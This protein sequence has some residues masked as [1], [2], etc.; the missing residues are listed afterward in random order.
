[1]KAQEITK[2]NIQELIQM[3]NS[4][5][6]PYDWRIPNIMENDT[7]SL[8]LIGEK[9]GGGW[10]AYAICNGHFDTNDLYLIVLEDEGEI[11]SFSTPAEFFARFATPE[12]L[13]EFW[14]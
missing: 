2:M 11:Q 13:A 4:N 8:D 1:M 10:L 7:E 3:H 14:D 12:Q 6:D 9:M 5:V